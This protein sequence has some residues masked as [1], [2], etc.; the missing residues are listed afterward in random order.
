[1]ASLLNQVVAV[2]A[3]NIRNIPQRAGI[4][5]VVVIGIAVTVAV[6]VSVLAM[7]AGFTRTIS[8]TGRVDRALVLRGG[9][10][11]ETASTIARDN[12]LTIMDAPGIRRDTDGKPLASAEMVAIVS[13]P[14]KNTNTKANIALRGIGPKGM[15]VRPE[16]KIVE[17]R[18]FRP[19]VL[20]LIVGKSA[21]AQFKGLNVGSH[22][23]Y[24][25]ADW[26]VVGIFDSGGDSHES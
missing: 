26:T 6:L 13:M 22:I 15:Q 19:A 24:H 8:N 11:T 9:S 2:T 17:G 1:M 14:L 16:I 23:N 7:A 4:S 18:M 3:N 12:T 25:N 20:E 21:A 10:E 5:A